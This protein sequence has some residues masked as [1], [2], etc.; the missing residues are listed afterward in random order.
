MA[1]V[2]YTVLPLYCFCESLLLII[3]TLFFLYL[4]RFSN[5][6]EL[7]R[8][9]SINYSTNDFHVIAFKLGEHTFSFS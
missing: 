1:T 8:G 5:D 3:K 2:P 9:G 7:K 6:C 4:L